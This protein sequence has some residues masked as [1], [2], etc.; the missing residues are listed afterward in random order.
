MLKNIETN[1]KM[2][3]KTLERGLILWNKTE[4]ET[5]L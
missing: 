5:S 4:S 2:E 1:L 3:F